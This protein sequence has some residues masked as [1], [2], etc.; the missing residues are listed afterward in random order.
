MT[1]FYHPNAE[2]KALVTLNEEESRHCARTLRMVKGDGCYLI[3]GRG[4]LFEAIVSEANPRATVLQVERIIQVKKPQLLIH[5]AIAPTKNADR[6]EWFLE[7]STE[8]G[9][10]RISPIICS[11]SERKKIRKDRLEKVVLSAT[12]QSQ[13]AWLPQIDNLIMYSDFID[14]LKNSHLTHK[15]IAHCKEQGQRITLSS[16]FPIPERILI[17][18]GP[19]GDFSEKEI[20][21]AIQAGFKEL[22]L[23]EAR[24]RTETAGIYAVS[25]LHALRSLKVSDY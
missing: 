24:L 17:I 23:G 13:K 11:H 22:T 9:I 16:I 19:E 2:E 25:A 18:I 6:F 15:Y 5:I 7:K 14:G 10:E 4:G 12:K 20:G 1:F 8:L 3:N 21:L